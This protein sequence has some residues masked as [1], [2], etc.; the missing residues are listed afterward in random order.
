MEQDYSPL[1]FKAMSTSR[2]APNPLR[3]YYIP[4][5]IGLPSE[6]PPT[7]ATQPGAPRAPPTSSKANFSSARDLF[8]DLDY[9]NYLP[10]RDSGGVADMT[11]RLVDQAIWNYTSVLLAQ[12]FEVAKIV[13]QCHLA[14]GIGTELQVSSTPGFNTSRP[15]DSRHD[16]PSRGGYFDTEDESDEDAPSY[17]A[18][19]APYETPSSPSGRRKRQPPDPSLSATQTP[20]SRSASSLSHNYSIELR[21]NDAILEVISQ[22][23]SKEGAW[24]IWKATNSTFVY[25][26]L[27]KTIETWSRSMLS[28][29][30]NM[31]DASLA[32]VGTSLAGGST[33]ILDSSNPMASIG[34]AVAAAGIAG[35]ILAPI[36]MIRTRLILTSV[37]AGPRAL[38][39]SLRALPSLFCPS[40]LLPITLLHSALPQLLSTSVPL[41]LRSSL[42]IDPVLTPTSSSIATFTLSLAE[43]FLKLPLEI[44]LRRGHIS[45]LA[46]EAKRER[47]TILHPTSSQSDPYSTP[48]VTQD[49]F[50]TL[51]PVGPYKGIVGTIWF[52]VREEGMSQRPLPLD[53][54]KEGVMQGRRPAPRKGQGMRGLWRGWRVGFWG[55][56]GMWSA[57][58][59]GGGGEGAF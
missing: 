51:L 12:P 17:F 8:S 45:I 16:A 29:L 52:I 5:S 40:P 54:L 22:L 19:T 42:H 44:V 35:L 47:M 18:P 30:L 38:L 2:D 11:K 43:L 37:D 3:P 33:N 50:R 46:A 10:E 56:V 14:D 9:E 49:R 7:N 34:I 28:A 32:G 41:F 59:L 6:P 25:N 58:A 26:I 31:P 24:G 1:S 53:V 48:Q 27:L 36:D 15:P 4:P 55:L 23:W 20:T 21:K 57:G 39:P 13:L